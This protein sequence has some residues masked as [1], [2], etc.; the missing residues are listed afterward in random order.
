MGH[1]PSI[2]K[3]KSF[4]SFFK[5][6]PNTYNWEVTLQEPSRPHGICK[7]GLVQTCKICPITPTVTNPITKMEVAH[8]MGLGQAG[9]DTTGQDEACYPSFG[10]KKVKKKFSSPFQQWDIWFLMVVDNNKSVPSIMSR[11]VSQFSRVRVP[12]L[13]AHGACLAGLAWSLLPWRKA[14]W[15]TKPHTSSVP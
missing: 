9:H 15:W 8:T 10:Q 14:F 4:G 12:C 6:N 13:P 5:S 2:L 3:K 7:L 11:D 1:A